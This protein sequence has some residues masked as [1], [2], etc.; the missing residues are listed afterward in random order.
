MVAIKI[1]NK[2]KKVNGR[3]G[4]H[5]LG[6]DDWSLPATTVVGGG[7]LTDSGCPSARFSFNRA[8]TVL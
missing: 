5:G 4:N 3:T 6:V 8:I 1:K 7:A 2:I